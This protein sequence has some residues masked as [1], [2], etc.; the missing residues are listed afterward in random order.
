LSSAPA[1]LEKLAKTCRED[2]TRFVR[3]CDKALFNPLIF[4]AS[5]ISQQQQ[6]HE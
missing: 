5:Y 6:Q 2:K 4:R 1:R 3:K